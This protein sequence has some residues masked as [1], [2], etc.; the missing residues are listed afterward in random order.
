MRAAVDL[1]LTTFPGQCT[2]CRAC[3]IACHFRHTA[4]F[5]T[6]AS[7]IRIDYEPDASSLQIHILPTCDLCAGAAIPACVAA[8]VPGAVVRAD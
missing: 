6:A 5:G 3:E 4:T 1:S 8:C 7:S 2:A